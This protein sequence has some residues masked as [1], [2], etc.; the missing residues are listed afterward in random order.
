MMKRYLSGML[1]VRVGGL[2]GQWNGRQTE[3]VSERV[4]G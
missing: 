1:D 2:S 3:R 4:D